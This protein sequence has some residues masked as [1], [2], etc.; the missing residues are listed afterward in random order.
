[1]I[2]GNGA[3]VP[4]PFGIRVSSGQS[5]PNP[6]MPRTPRMVA[7][8]LYNQ[9]LDLAHNNQIQDARLKFEQ[10]IKADPTFE[11]AWETLVGSCM[12][13]GHLEE[14]IAVGEQFM[15]QFPHSSRHSNVTMIVT[16]LKAE[17]EHKN[18]I[19]QKTG[20]DG[21]DSYFGLASEG[22]PKGWDLSKM[23][24][25]VFISDGHGVKGYRSELLATLANSFT[26]WSLAT[27]KH[28]QFVKVD[29][30]AEADIECS[31]I[32]DPKQFPRNTGME[33]GVALP[34]VDQDGTVVHAQIMILTRDRYNGK[35]ETELI[36]HGVC[37]HEIGHA[38]GLLGHSDNPGDT[39]FF[40]ESWQKVQEP[41]LSQRDVNTL[42][43]L[44]S[45]IASRKSGALIARQQDYHSPVATAVTPWTMQ[46]YCGGKE[47]PNTQCAISYFETAVKGSPGDLSLLDDL[48]TAYCNFAIE[49]MGRNEPRNAEQYLNLAVAIHRNSHDQNRLLCSLNNLVNLLHLQ[50]RDAEATQLQQSCQ[51]LLARDR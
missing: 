42:A 34:L 13:S 10:S 2:F 19:W 14:G 15:R 22:A 51:S 35:P 39:M 1:M 43:K 4:V 49:Q 50:Q 9:G 20:P 26:E 38:L 40:S 33:A 36:V 37:L 44:Y 25:K 7:G 23:P 11:A 17:L 21:V 29:T 32:D 3:G 41:H 28:M 16:K 31:W 27:D 45:V 6:N 48:G 8:Q 5:N 47:F 24:L 46:P 12:L 30:P 18:Q